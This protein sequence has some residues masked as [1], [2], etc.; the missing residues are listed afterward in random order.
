[1]VRT[2]K[3]TINGDV[4]EHSVFYQNMFEMTEVN[5][6]I[7]EGRP[8]EPFV[9]YHPG[10]KVGLLAF[11]DQESIPKSPYPVTVIFTPDLDGIVGRLQE[12][13]QPVD[14][15]SPSDARGLRIAITRDPSGN[16]L[17]IIERAGIPAVGGAKL[18]VEDRQKA[19]EFFVDLF[20]VSAGQRLETDDFDEVIMNFGRKMF[21]AL[22]EPKG[23]ELVAKSESPVV[24]I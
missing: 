5:R 7:D 1:M 22:F 21:V 20:A 16:V 19:E 17:E 24:A 6:Y 11:Q 23:I 8:V 3:F 12:A 13:G 9:G 18:I 4:E 15:L 2:T 10:A 14:Q